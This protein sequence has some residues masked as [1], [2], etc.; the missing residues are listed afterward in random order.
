VGGL[1]VG[2]VTTVAFA[3]APRK[4]R[5]LFQAGAALLILVVLIVIAVLRA[6]HLTSQLG[7]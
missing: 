4:N 3:Y 2:A 5:T 6:H 1:I 7:L